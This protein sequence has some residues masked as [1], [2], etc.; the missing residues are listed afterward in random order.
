[1]RLTEKDI[2]ILNNI[3][4]TAG[5]FTMIIAVTM[6]FSLLQLKI[7][8]PLDSPVILSVKE[9]YDKNPADKQK[10]EEVRAMDLMA[11]RAYFSSRWQVETGSYLLLAGAV[12]FVLSKR[13]IA[14]SEKPAPQFP[15]AKTDIALQKRKSQKYLI[16]SASV[17]TAAA[18]ISSLLLRSELPAP[19]S[20]QAGTVSSESGDK[21]LFSAPGGINY[22]FFRGEGSRGI[23]G[24][25][26]YP[27]EWNGNEGKNI[28]WK[29]PVPAPGKSS[30]VI[31]LDKL[32]ITG[33]NGSKCEV[34][35]IDKNKGEILWTASASDFPGASAVVPE[36][37]AD[38]GMAVSTAAVN[39]E[40]V[41]AVFGNGN[42]ACF[43]LN[44][45]MKWA[46]NIG[47]PANMYGYSA[48]LLI[49][50]KILI[51]QF[52]SDEKIALLGLDI[53]SGNV[54]WETARSG[55][56]V[57]SSP[58]LAIYDGQ[59]QVIINGDPD[60]SSYDPL[61]GKELWRTKGVSN[62][63]TPSPAVNS[64]FVFIVQNYAKLMAIRPGM[65]SAPLW[66]DNS[67]TP[68]VSSPVA[69]EEYLF[70]CDGAGSA[71]CYKPDKGEIIW[72]NDFNDPFYASPIIADNKVYFL[73]R[74]GVMHI[75]KATDKF[76]LIADS[77][78]GED[79]DCTPA[80]S[81][82]KI[83]VR[84]KENLYCISVN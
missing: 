47:V 4:L 9:Q 58:V 23:A 30:P 72:K 14:G 33:A 28:K 10:A 65:N 7:M 8:K 78:L 51:V 67:Y 13:I 55:K 41:C 70:I 36:S 57:W 19:G 32:F 31:W 64:K 53:S 25:E 46:K 40:V 24:G 21:G 84:G 35:C 68:D 56:P 44:G 16:I 43:D 76:E 81:E 42:I 22:P 79:A 71:A 54:T 60:V 34:F 5:I 48:S 1:M 27:A 26:S 15:E 37:D 39:G 63:V 80:F 77:P 62:D 83:Y 59:P 2:K 11:R 45:K 74:T 82:G 6:I 75:V 50:G 69:N 66:E 38:A 73:D 29:I 18:L 17:I 49:H 61:T 52:D 12:I 20:R 3:S